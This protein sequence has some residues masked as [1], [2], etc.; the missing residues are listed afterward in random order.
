MNSKMAEN[1][2]EQSIFFNG[3]NEETPLAVCLIYIIIYIYI[4]NS[5]NIK[6]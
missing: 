1:Y 6:C 4:C 5:Y 3:F 2:K